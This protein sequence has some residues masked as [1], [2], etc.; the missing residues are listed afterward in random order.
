MLPE[1][2]PTHDDRL[3][4][5]GDQVAAAAELD[6]EELDDSVHEWLDNLMYESDM[7]M[8]SNSLVIDV[9][10]RRHEHWEVREK[11]GLESV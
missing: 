7:E 5:T 10:N 9:Q 4:L 6:I 8:S 1:R 2:F 11:M 3:H